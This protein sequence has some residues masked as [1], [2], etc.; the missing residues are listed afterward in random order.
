[1]KFKNVK[2]VL[3]IIQGTMA[4]PPTSIAKMAPRLILKYFG[5]SDVISERQSEPNTRKFKRRHLP[6]PNDT[7]FALIFTQIWARHQ[8]S[9]Q[10]KAAALPPEESCHVATMSRG[11]HIALPYIDLV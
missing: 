5:K 11:C 10:K 1:M 3:R 9:A 2:A 8:R 6:L 4:H 7:E